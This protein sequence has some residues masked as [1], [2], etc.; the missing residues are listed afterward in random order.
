[1]IRFDGERAVLRWHTFNFEKLSGTFLRKGLGKS[2]LPKL[3]R[4][5]N[6]FW[7]NYIRTPVYEKC[8]K[9]E[10]LSKLSGADSKMF[11]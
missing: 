11:L 9:S 1:M 4:K 6:H 5:R 7:C 10:P 3:E 8:A 2:A